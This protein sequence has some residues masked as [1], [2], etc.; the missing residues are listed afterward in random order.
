MNIMD[1]MIAT[2]GLGWVRC[3]MCVGAVALF[4]YGTAQVFW[5][6]KRRVFFRILPGLLAGLLI[7]AATGLLI[8]MD[9]TRGDVI[10]SLM[11]A[12][13]GG[14]FDVAAELVKAA[15]T[16]SK[17]FGQGLDIASGILNA[18]G[19]T[20]IT[21]IVDTVKTMIIIGALFSII[22]AVVS[23]AREKI[24]VAL[25]IFAYGYT[26]VAV[27]CL[28][29]GQPSLLSAVL[30]IVVGALLGVLGYRISRMWIIITTSLVGG[31]IALCS[32]VSL[33]S[34]V[35]KIPDFTIANDALPKTLGQYYMWT[36][37]GSLLGI[38]MWGAVWAIAVGSLQRALSHPISRT[39]III[40]IGLY[41]IL[42]V[43]STVMRASLVSGILAIVALIIC[44]IYTQ[45][46]TTSTPSDRAAAWPAAA[47]ADPVLRVLGHPIS[48]MQMVIVAGIC[49]VLTCLPTSLLEGI[50]TEMTRYIGWI[51][52]ILRMILEMVFLT[53]VS[54]Y[55]Q[56][57]AMAAPAGKTAAQPA[58]VT[59]DSAAAL[60]KAAPS[61]ARPKAARAA[62][63]T[64]PA[65]GQN[66]CAKCGKPLEPGVKF[67]GKCGHPTRSGG[68]A[69]KP[70]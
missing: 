42:L 55:A 2:I 29:A 10:R 17:A 59:A 50:S 30:A 51:V 16:N 18:V 61:P 31:S 47:S 9:G 7:S 70:V 3:L 69:E 53:V 48:R 4:V 62:K 66:F 60:D 22:C 15:V 33:T 64:P 23:A 44:G 11:E 27:L 25:E 43:I 57:K 54:I 39:K 34:L 13:H 38:L 49:A 35:M 28:S 41:L 19:A 32:R 68:N 46:K 24:G 45:L 20:G 1:T 14:I 67:C 36:F 8:L 58:A 56:Q 63:E 26:L 65:G 12:T 6:Y 52:L 37:I 21:D 5:G 40:T